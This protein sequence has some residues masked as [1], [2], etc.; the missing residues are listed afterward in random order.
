MPR[1]QEVLSL[2]QACTGPLRTHPQQ[3]ARPGPLR[4]SSLLKRWPLSAGPTQAALTQ[5][6]LLIYNRGA[7][8]CP[9]LT[10]RNQ[11]IRILRST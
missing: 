10:H 11:L 3:A 4:F 8:T 9:D 7:Q 2:Q 5:P 6:T 1:P